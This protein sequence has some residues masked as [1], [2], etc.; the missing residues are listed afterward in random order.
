MKLPHVSGMAICFLPLFSFLC[1]LLPSSF[2]RLLILCMRRLAIP[3]TDS[4]FV[5]NKTKQTNKNSPSSPRYP[6]HESGNV[7]ESSTNSLAVSCSEDFPIKP[8][9]SSLRLHKISCVD[10]CKV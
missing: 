9:N 1:S 7:A 6:P 3:F 8:Q 4:F 5:A 10:K 2:Q